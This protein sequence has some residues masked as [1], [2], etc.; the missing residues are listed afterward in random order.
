MVRS[1]NQVKIYDSEKVKWVAIEEI[2]AVWFYR[3][4]MVQLVKRDIVARYKRSTLGVLWT[5]LNP[6]AT[7]IILTIVFS[8]FF[9]MRSV[10]PAYII[11]GLITWSFFSQT[12]LF[13]LN[14]T[15]RGS[16]LYNKIYLPQTAFVISVLGGGILNY[17][18]SIIPMALIFLVTKVPIHPTVLLFPVGLLLLATFTLGL[19][20]LLS[21]GVVFFPDIAEFAPVILQAWFYIT[22][23]IYPAELQL[24]IMGG[25][26][27]KINPMY[28]FI[29]IIR[30]L[31]YD[32][33]IPSGLDWLIG[34]AIAILML[35]IGWWVF[36]SKSK[37]FGYQ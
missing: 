32:G 24:D 7:M 12:I 13:S 35:V 16:D 17:L 1:K 10:Y 28:Y 21:T 5:M 25:L 23:I 36:T 20:L 18:L 34:F 19:G 14:T 9:N 4:L 31:L 22:P 2:K 8:R 6:L 27:L 26:F 3:D 30:N 11:T 29:K 37:R 15:L 33:V